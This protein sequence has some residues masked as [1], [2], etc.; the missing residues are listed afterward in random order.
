[1][2]WRHIKHKQPT[3]SAPQTLAVHYTGFWARVMGFITD[4]F[5]IGM[6]VSLFMMSVFGRDEMKTATALDVL[7][8]SET[9][10]ENAPDPLVSIIHVILTM[11]IYVFMW[12]RN[13]QTPGKKIA[14]SKVVDAKTLQQAS[15]LQLMVRFIAYFLSAITLMGFFTGLLRRDKRTL[16]DL[17]SRTAV[18]Y[19][20]V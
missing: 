9:A 3:T 8:K 20:T 17:L 14:R 2:R 19:T 18:I 7:S 16:H 11:A 12:H 10:L 15:Y 13:G 5:M 4:L 1:M 6:P